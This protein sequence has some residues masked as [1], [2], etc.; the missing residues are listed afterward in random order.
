[1]AEAVSRPGGDEE[2]RYKTFQR[3]GAEAQRIPDFMK[4]FSLRLRAAQGR[5]NAARGHDGRDAGGRVMQ[6]ANAE[7]P[8]APAAAVIILFRIRRR[9]ILSLRHFG[10][11][12][13]GNS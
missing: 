2:R 1:M 10:V 5:G 13:Q 12:V 8:E 3:R 6:G 9:T 4:V 11:H 7:E